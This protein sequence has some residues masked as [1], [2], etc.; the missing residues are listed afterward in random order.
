MKQVQIHQVDAFTGIAFGGNPAGVVPDARG[1]TDDEMQKIAREMA[2]SET[3]FVVPGERPRQF[4]VRFFTPSTEVNLC[5]HAT[6]GTFFHLAEVGIIGREPGQQVTRVYQVTKAGELAVDIFWRPEGGPERVMMEQNSPERLATY[7]KPEEIAEIASMLGTGPDVIAG[8]RA[9]A[10]GAAR[11]G[12]HPGPNTCACHAIV[13]CHD[14]VP[15]VVSTGLPDLIVPVKSCKALWALKPDLNRVADWSRGHGVISVHA[16]ALDPVDPAHTGHCRDFS[17]AVAVPEEAATGTASG[18]TAGYLVLNGVVKAEPVAQIV[19]EQGDILK[20]P[21]LIHCEIRR[22][23]GHERLGVWVG[24]KAVT[25]L[26][27]A[28][29][30]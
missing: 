28:M 29:R 16:V 5:G 7:G 18:A 25:V 9:D 8:V 6:I 30:F 26:S 15:Q 10:T 23:R 14:L 2:L 4:V 17:P 13:A 3:A 27:G 22:E 24:G 1:L 12:A 21:S 19:L 11:P 20:R